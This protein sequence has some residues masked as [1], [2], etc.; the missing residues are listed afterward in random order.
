MSDT[1]ELI[2]VDEAARL[3]RCHANTM[4]VWI[5]TGAIRHYKRGGR[6]FLNPDDVLAMFAQGGPAKEPP[7]P[8]IDRAA[9]D[10]WNAAQFAKF[11]IK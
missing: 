7:P 10:R 4:R 1:K 5:K 8:V 6:Y 11:G 9:R 2:S 3:A